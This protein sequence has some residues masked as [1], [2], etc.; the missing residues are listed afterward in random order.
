MSRAMVAI[1]R[2]PVAA[3]NTLDRPPTDKSVVAL[4]SRSAQRRD[5][6]DVEAGQPHDVDRAS[7][8]CDDLLR[9]IL[10]DP[11]FGVRLEVRIREELPAYSNLSSE[12]IRAT[13][14]LKFA[15]MT[16]DCRS[17]VEPAVYERFFSAGQ[18]RA[19]QGVP[20]GEMLQAYRI[21]HQEIRRRARE[22]LVGNDD[23]EQLMLE[24]FERSAAYIDAAMVVTA[25]GH[26][27]AELEK[28]W[29][30]RHHHSAI[31]RKVLIDGDSSSAL[32]SDLGAFGIDC[33]QPFYAVR[34]RPG[35]DADLDTLYRHMKQHAR[36]GPGNGLISVIDHDICGF[37]ATKP[38]MVPPTVIGISERVPFLDLPRAF[39]HATRA[40][41]TALAFDLKPGMYDLGALGVRAAVAAD[42]DIGS[43][44]YERF[45]APF[46]RRGEPGVVI[47]DT[48]RRYLANGARLDVTAEEL[49]A[50]VN[51]VRYRINRFES[52]TGCSLKDTDDVVAI[53][54]A[55]QYKRTRLYGRGIAS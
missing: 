3:E 50:H 48:V 38:T 54:W 33:T 29:H 28:R 17:F 13:P 30:D 47:V 19:R 5:A 32:R 14:R 44:L 26:H 23:G 45:L 16:R 22:L 21:S 43:E 8:E 37:V 46:E 53:W 35:A 15:E 34:A 18:T 25:E 1:G 55:L 40:M 6:S 4:H 27:S 36:T 24:L 20:V 42:H 31:V 52:L 7:A 11:T 39:E 10:A 12:Q 2:Q 9:R 51:T 49:W 41:S